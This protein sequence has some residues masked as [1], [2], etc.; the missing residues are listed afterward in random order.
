MIRIYTLYPDRCSEDDVA[1]ANAL[2]DAKER[3]R[4]DRF[5]FP[6]HARL[7]TLAHGLVR[8]TLQA[9]LGTSAL[10]FSENQYGKPSVPGIEFNL[11]HTKG[12]VALGLS[13]EGALGVDV[14]TFNRGTDVLSVA[15]H[16]FSDLEAADVTATPPAQRKERFFRYWTLKESYIKARGMGLH[17]PLKA[18]SFLL[19]EP[20]ATHTNRIRITMRADLN[21]TP[22]RWYFE[23][24]KLD[25]DFFLAV[26]TERAPNATPLIT[27]MP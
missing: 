27:H 25:G 8:R 4:R 16:S 12:L 22:E 15:Q 14:E 7:Y 2:L 5:V 17:L 19:D 11:S 26:C 20:D 21:D 1:A 9:H 10:V 3:D 24:T 23:Q 6:E 13:D 18:F